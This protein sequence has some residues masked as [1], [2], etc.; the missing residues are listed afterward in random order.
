M[1]SRRSASRGSRP[2]FFD[3]ENLHFVQIAGGLF[4]IT[5]DKRHSSAVVQQ[6]DHR[7]QAAHRKVQG[8]GDVKKDFRGEVFCFLHECLHSSY[9]RWTWWCAAVACGKLG[10]RT[11][12]PAQSQ[13]I[14]WG[15]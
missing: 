7:D 2:A 14:G 10:A 15:R 8:L 1:V 4:A 12:H 5:R 3:G 11:G 9:M 13:G 6:F